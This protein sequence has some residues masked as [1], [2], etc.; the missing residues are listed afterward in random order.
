LFRRCCLFVMPSL[1]EPFGIAPLEA[2]V[3]RIPA[4]VT[5]A[6]ALKETVTP[7][8]TGDLVESGDVDDLR[9]KLIALLSDPDAL[10]RMGARGRQVVLERYTWGS[11]V[12]RAIQ[13]M[14]V[15]GRLARP[16]RGQA[17]RDCPTNGVVCCQAAG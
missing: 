1:Y 4:L 11:V 8:E 7:G 16:G 13:A 6:S 5:N 3:N 17:S 10:R 2:M 15:C 12:E 14:A 9:S